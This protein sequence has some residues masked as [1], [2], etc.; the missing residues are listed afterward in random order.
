MNLKEY[1]IKYDIISNSVNESNKAVGL[2]EPVK[3]IINI[4]YDG[5]IGMYDDPTSLL[6]INDCFTAEELVESNI[7]DKPKRKR[8]RPRKQK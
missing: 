1:F 5:K 4:N 3:H 8:G 6:Q 2:E 7:I